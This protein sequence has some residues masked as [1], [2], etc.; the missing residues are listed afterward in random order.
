MSSMF[1]FDGMMGKSVSCISMTKC[2][3]MCVISSDCEENMTKVWVT[4]VAGFLGS[5]LADALLAAGHEVGGNDNMSGGDIAN[6]PTGVD[7]YKLDCNERDLLAGRL[8][9]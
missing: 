2:F 7:L 4:G 8:L 3:R 5:H 9:G 6:V 1:V